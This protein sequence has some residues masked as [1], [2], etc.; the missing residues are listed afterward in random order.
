M[1]DA[2]IA[3]DAEAG[4]GRFGGRDGI[5]HADNSP[6]DV[7]RTW[8][9]SNNSRPPPAYAGH[10]RQASASAERLAWNANNGKFQR[11]ARSRVRLRKEGC[12][13]RPT[14]ETVH[15]AIQ[16]PAAK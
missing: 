4:H 13:A 9:R 5:Q 11:I 16:S 6:G 2:R 10:S 3:I 15:W 8:E 12:G 14:P 7:C 1:G